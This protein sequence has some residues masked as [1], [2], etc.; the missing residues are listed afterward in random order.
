MIRSIHRLSLSGVQPT[1]NPFGCGVT[2]VLLVLCL[3]IRNLFLLPALIAGL[4][5]IPA[6]RVTAQTIAAGVSHSLSVCNDNTV[7][8]WGLNEDGQL[9]N[10]TINNSYVPVQ[11]SS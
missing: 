11:A 9:G 3:R 6:G 5:L 10:G 4:G 7:R 1:S 2:G 8:A